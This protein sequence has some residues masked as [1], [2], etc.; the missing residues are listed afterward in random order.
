[1]FVNTDDIDPEYDEFSVKADTDYAEAWDELNEFL[2]SPGVSSGN[3]PKN[4]KTNFSIPQ[5]PEILRPDY[6]NMEVAFGTDFNIIKKAYKKLII[7]YHPDKNSNTPESL[8][9]ATEKS[10]NLN[11]SYQKIK[12]W[13]LA[14]K[15]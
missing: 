10:K 5:P 8:H 12:A 13:E 6:V 1:M 3:N 4:T 11:I 2:S 7:L 14:K 15:G 9:I